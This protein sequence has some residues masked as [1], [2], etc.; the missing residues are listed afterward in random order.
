MKMS[1]IF[2]N[3]NTARKAWIAF[4]G[5]LALGAI[6]ITMR[7]LPSMRREINLMRM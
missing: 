3:E 5:L 1:K 4:G 6:V 7:E 2:R